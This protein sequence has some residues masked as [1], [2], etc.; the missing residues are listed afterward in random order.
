MS[1]TELSKLLNIFQNLQQGE[2]TI[3]QYSGYLQYLARR[4]DIEFK[5]YFNLTEYFVTFYNGLQQIYKDA[6]DSHNV[7]TYADAVY[8]ATCIETGVPVELDQSDSTN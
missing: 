8:V 5:H 1:E 6:I 7:D 3:A 2:L 4:L